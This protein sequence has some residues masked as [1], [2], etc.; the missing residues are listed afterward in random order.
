M[1]QGNRIN[2]VASIVFFLFYVVWFSVD[3]LVGNPIAM[4]SVL[5]LL[6][7][8]VLYFVALRSFDSVYYLGILIFTFL[9]QFL[10]SYLHFYARFS[11]YDLILHTSSGVLLALLAHYLFGRFV[12]KSS[13]QVPLRVTLL[14]CLLFAIASAAVWEIWE[15]SGDMLFGRQAQGNLIDTMTDIIGGSCG[16]IAG[17]LIVWLTSRKS[18]KTRDVTRQS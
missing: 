11:L 6:G 10:G 8:S 2:L 1:K 3:A 16:G 18:A 4:D 12:L 15:F 17:T 7:A 9:A 13:E 5:L 14:V